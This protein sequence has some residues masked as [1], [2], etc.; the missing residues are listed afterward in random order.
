MTDEQYMKLALKLAAK[1]RG[2]TSPNPMVGA[3]LVKN[4]RIIGQGYHQCCGQNHAEINALANATE[5]VSGSTLYV[6]LEP[7][8]HYGK[9]P[10]CADKILQHKI[11]RVVIGATDS[12][13]LVSGQG[14]SR[15]QNAGV[16]VSIGVLEA[17]C[18]ELNEV[19]FH[20]MQTGLPY[21]TIKYAQTLDGRIATA[22]GHSQWISSPASLRFAHQLRAEHD[23]IL[24]GA[25]TVFHDDPTL[26]VRLVRGRNPLRIVVDS[27]LDL[28]PD[29]K[30][31]QNLSQTPTLIATTQK[32]SS[33]R[34]RSLTKAGAELLTLPPDEL[35]HVNLKKLL[36][37]LAKRNISSVLIEGG[38]QIIT[39]VLK[40]NLACRLVAVIAPKIIGKGIEA[41]GDLNIQNLKDAK[42]LSVRK[43]IRKGTDI[44]LD[45]RL[46]QPSRS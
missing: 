15:L 42:C 46:T 12:N 36:P 28:S 37:M 29:A 27:K 31:L 14:V 44:I 43:V 26:T 22:T 41:V 39:S 21:I 24:V 33:E 13:P 18:L 45:C 35:G 9:T 30:I 2:Y 5:N 3:V 11:K 20:Y 32:A 25:K 8:S 10:P 17:E 16:E 19:F 1:G 7:C 38:G 4:D 34:F 40:D 23:A 6:T